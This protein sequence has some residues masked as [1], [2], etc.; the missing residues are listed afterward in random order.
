MLI[1]GNTIENISKIRQILK[2][3]CSDTFGSYGLVLWTKHIEDLDIF[4][5]K[6]SID[7]RNKTYVTPLFIIGL[8]K[9]NY[10]KNG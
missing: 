3:I 4:K 8:D 6:I 1:D 7:A 5:D 2:H 9:V 10:K